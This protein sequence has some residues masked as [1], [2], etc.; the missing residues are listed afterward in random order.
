MTEEGKSLFDKQKKLLEIKLVTKNRK[1]KI[2]STIYLKYI[3]K[4]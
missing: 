1:K 2:E 3:K 4:K